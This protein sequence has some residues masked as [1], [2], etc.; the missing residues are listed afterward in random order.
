MES[1]IETRIQL[2]KKSC[3]GNWE[4]ENRPWNHKMR[5]DTVGKSKVEKDL[6]GMV[7][8]TPEGHINGIFGSS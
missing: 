7:Q 1:K 3:V 8:D 2:W 6:G 4:K 5:E